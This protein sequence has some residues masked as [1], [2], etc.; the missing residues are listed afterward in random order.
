MTAKY[1]A[2]AEQLVSL[3][4]QHTTLEDA[5]ANLQRQLAAAQSALSQLTTDVSTLQCRY[6]ATK[7]LCVMYR[8]DSL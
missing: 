6:D 7:V 1:R 8:V 3:Q 5:H 2:E 4:R